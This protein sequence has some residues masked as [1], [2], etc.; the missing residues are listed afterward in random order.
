ML[1]QLHHQFDETTTE[2]CAQREIETAEDLQ[3]FT[4]DTQENHPL[5]EGAE[6]LV[7]GEDSEHF[8]WTTE[9]A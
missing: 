6:W 1:C 8:V 3:E 5:P 4:R 7:V 9:D 2:F